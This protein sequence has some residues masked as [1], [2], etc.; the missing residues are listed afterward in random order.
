M[1][2]I[3]T[4]PNCPPCVATKRKLAQLGLEYTEVPLTEESAAAFKAQ[5]YGS[6][7]V[8][9]AGQLAWCGY[10]PELIEGLVE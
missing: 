4:R 5:G 9:V 8:V 7:P 1:I 3:H 2:T 10:R 6:A